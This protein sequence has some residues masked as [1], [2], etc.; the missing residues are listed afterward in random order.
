MGK[1]AYVN[2]VPG[3]DEKF[4]RAVITK[5][6]SD[7]EEWYVESRSVSREDFIGQ[8]REGD[9][10]V[11]AC[12][13]CL[14]QT[15]GDWRAKDADLKDA[16]GEI[17]GQ[18]AVLVSAYEKMR[19]DKDWPAMKVAAKAYFNWI[20]NIGNASARKHLYTDHEIREMLIVRANKN[21]KNWRDRRAAVKAKG[22]K[23]PGRTWFVTWL[24]IEADRR[25]ITI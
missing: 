4:Q 12:V 16:R 1:R 17:N 25:R 6:F 23:P 22:I 3:F 9:E 11:V 7:I 24:P 5:S 13:G 8:L 20:K 21:L 19:S 10:A 14:A 2:P 15:I 18:G